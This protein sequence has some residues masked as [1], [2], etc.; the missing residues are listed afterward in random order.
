MGMYDY[1]NG[2]QVKC[3][4]IGV[5]YG[6]NE[7]CE[8]E[9]STIGGLLRSIN[10]GDEVPYRSAI[11][12]YG[13]DFLI[14]DFMGNSLDEFLDKEIYSLYIVENGILKDEITIDLDDKEIL[15]KLS[16]IEKYR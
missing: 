2:N 5:I 1:L 3:F 4:P 13:K 9:F 6:Y 8:I 11:Y 7:K 15:S 14:L 10:T 16:V 12:N